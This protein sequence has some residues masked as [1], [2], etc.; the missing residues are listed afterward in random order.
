LQGEWKHAWV[1][2]VGGDRS[3]VD[4]AYVQA[5]WFL[6]GENRAYKTSSGVFGRVTPR[7][8]FDPQNGGWGA[9][10]LAA[11]YSFIDINDP[12]L[13]AGTLAPAG[14]GGGKE[15]NVTA[16]INWYLFSN[17]RLTANYVYAD[18][19]NTGEQ[20]VDDPGVPTFFPREDGD[21][22]L[23]QARAQIEF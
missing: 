20:R 10:E 4:G 16:G 22:H 3:Q 6:T 19:G 8:S 7:R 14:G 23:F 2:P 11:R 18:V 21:I 12:D 1:D 13:N 5:S 9:F 17:L 15:Q